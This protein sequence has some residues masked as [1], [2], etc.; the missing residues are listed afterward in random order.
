MIINKNIHSLVFC[1]TLHQPY[2]SATEKNVP[3]AWNNTLFPAM[4]DTYI[5]LLRMFDS[6]AKEKI[7]FRLNMLITP[8]LCSL[9]DDYI[10]Q[11]QY[12]V[13][14]ENLIDLGTKELE[15]TKDD[16]DLHSLTEIYVKNLK[17]VYSYF[18]GI[19]QGTLLPKFAEYVNSGHIELMATS[20]EHCYLPHFVSLDEVLNA[21][22]EAGMI[23]HRN[24]FGF[25][26]DGFWLP[27]MGY[28]D[29]LEKSIQKYG[30]SYTILDTHGFL[31][32]NPAPQ[33]G[34]FSPLR[35]KNSLAIFTRDYNS[36]T[37]IFGSTGFMHNSVYRDPHRDIGFESAMADLPLFFQKD[38]ARYATG[39]KYWARKGSD[40]LYDIDV[41]QKQTELDSTSFV[42]AKVA[43]LT[44][45]SNALEGKAV[46][47]VCTL[48]GQDLGQNWYEG[49]NWLSQVFRKIA[50]QEGLKCEVCSELLEDR[51]TLQKT[52]FF[53]S[54]TEGSGYGENLLDNTNSWML[55]YGRKSIERMID[56]AERFPDDSGLKERA[57]NL[58]ARQVLFA[59]SSDWPKMIHDGVNAEQ[60]EN[61][62]TQSILDFST[63]FD[64][65][66]ANCIS[67]E[68]LTQTEKEYPFFPWINYRIFCKKVR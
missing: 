21:Q 67:T 41:A 56:L 14:L 49:I 20:V 63:I 32:A 57:L 25:V 62:F 36:W 15:R 54:A 19:C 7:P 6:L 45:A 17:Q 23:A 53:M 30:F 4:T 35:C 46:S 48:D 40:V 52:E 59:I 11:E 22:I 28:A 33:S 26:P 55:R 47:L 8:T 58:A 16:N 9:L 38:Q 2:F 13:W 42:D 44:A 43:K 1:I 5:P 50:Q 65:L 10:V 24:F 66:G 37:E 31:F 18:V 29:G 60:A 27:L 61:L 12:T 34:I 68:W 3:D 51:F 39:F 64:S